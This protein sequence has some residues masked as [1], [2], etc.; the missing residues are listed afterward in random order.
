MLLLRKC[1]PEK[2]NAESVTKDSTTAIATTGPDWKAVDF[3]A[4]TMTDADI[5]DS[6]IQ[7]RS[8]GT[9][10]IYSLGENILFPTDGNEVSEAGKTKLKIISDVLNNRFKE[11]T[12]GV[13]GATDSTGPADEKSRIG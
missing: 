5:A 3:A 10:T 6:D 7:T 2:S 11:A 1:D 9:Y 8:N 4:A 12:I 13:F